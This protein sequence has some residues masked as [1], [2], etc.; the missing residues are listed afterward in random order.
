MIRVVIENVLLLLLPT[1]LYL[2]FIYI[3][4]GRKGSNQG[5]LDDAPLI[6]LFLAGVGLALAVI[7]MFGTLEGSAPGQGYRP[8]EFR[9]GKIVPGEVEKKP[10][11][12]D[13]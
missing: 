10:R 12:S 8:P 5:V 3:S 9:D 4:G 2:A 13:G 6:W 11:P 1:I 7:M